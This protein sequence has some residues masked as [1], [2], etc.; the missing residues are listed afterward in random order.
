MHTA[1]DATQCLVAGLAPFLDDEM[2]VYSSAH[3]RR[4]RS[5]I[6][7]IQRKDEYYWIVRAACNYLLQVGRHDDFVLGV[8]VATH[9]GISLSAFT[10]QFELANNV[11]HSNVYASYKFY[12]TKTHDEHMGDIWVVK[13]EQENINA[14]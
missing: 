10:R 7:Y 6:P 4:T 13:V 11:D 3:R 12:A 2:R 14:T 1:T 8:A 9:Q 5:H